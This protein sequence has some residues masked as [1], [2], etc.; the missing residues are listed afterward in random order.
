MFSEITITPTD[1][2]IPLPDREPWSMT[3][4]AGMPHDGSFPHAILARIAA[5]RFTA[6]AREN[7]YN[8]TRV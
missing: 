4:D 5:N 2:L 7:G 3:R 6:W 1:V 8:V